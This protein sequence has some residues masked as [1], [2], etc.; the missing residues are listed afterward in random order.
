ML[1]ILIIGLV[2][3]QNPENLVYKNLF[4]DYRANK[5]VRPLIGLAILDDLAQEL[6]EKWVEYPTGKYKITI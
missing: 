2:L 5:K 4:N 6:A 1:L 3:G